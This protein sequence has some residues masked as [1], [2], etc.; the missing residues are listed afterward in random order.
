MAIADEGDGSAGFGVVFLGWVDT[1]RLEE[2]GGHIVGGDGLMCGPATGGIAFADDLST[3]DSATG[4]EHEH[5]AGVVITTDEGIAGIEFG[6]AA[7]FTGHED[8]GGFE[9]SAFLET[10]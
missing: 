6:S 1:E 10:A 4:H 3:A 8:D 9:E 2:G 5:A 7:E